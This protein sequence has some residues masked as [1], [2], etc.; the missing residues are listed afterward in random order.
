MIKIEV[1]RDGD[2]IVS[3]RCKG[4]AGYG[5]PGKDL[6][7]AGVST[8]LFGLMNALDELSNQITLEKKKN[9]L[10]IHSDIDDQTINAYLRCGYIQ[11]KTIGDAYPEYIQME[12]RS[13]K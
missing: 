11:L 13:S 12:E 8:V 7:C 1:L 4:H 3:L 9:S 10:Y 5:E 6:I 2:R